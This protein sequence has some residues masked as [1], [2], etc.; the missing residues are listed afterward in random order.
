MKKIFAFI[1]DLLFFLSTTFVLFSISLVGIYTKE[2][3]ISVINTVLQTNLI[4]S[5]LWTYGVLVALYVFYTVIL[6]RLLGATVGQ[7]LLGLSLQPKENRSI[8]RIFMYSFFGPFWAI[9][10]FPYSLFALIT[11]KDSITFRL[12]G[13]KLQK[14][15]GR[16]SIR[17]TLFTSLFALMLIATAGISTYVYKAGITQIIEQYTDYKKQTEILIDKLAFKDAL[18]TL[19]KYKQYHGETSD[20]AYLNCL[21]NGNLS[22]TSASLEICA[23]AKESNTTE[24]R[25]LQI[26]IIEARILSANGNYAEAVTKYE[27]LWTTRGIHTIDMKDYVI[28]LNEMGKNDV[29]LKVVDEIA[30]GVNETDLNAQIEVGQLYERVNKLDVAQKTYETVLSRIKEG[31]QTELMGEVVFNI[32]VIQY[33]AGKYPEAKLNF[34]KAKT[35]NKDFSD[36]A[37][38]YIILISQLGN[39]VTK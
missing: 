39:S 6:T 19:A 8:R 22:T 27:E 14:I 33:K 24:E 16:L 1:L 38:S 29:A 23:K 7:K 13:L 31:E 5:L 20:Y 25:T 30:K 9:L 15:E 21:I 2:K 36:D 10:L 4:P 3:D 26:L 11:K 32:A 17:A 28:V 12:S 37:D 35:L 18:V 34:E